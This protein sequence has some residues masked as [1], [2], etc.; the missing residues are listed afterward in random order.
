MK[1]F[2]WVAYLHFLEGWGAQDNKVNLCAYQTQ[3]ANISGSKLCSFPTR[4]GKQI[5]SLIFISKFQWNKKQTIQS[6]SED[7][8]WRK[9][10]VI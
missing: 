2:A 7:Q 9:E 5:L 1:N 4:K 10:L 3:I 8:T 6:K